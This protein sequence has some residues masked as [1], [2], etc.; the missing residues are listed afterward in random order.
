[1]LCTIQ[2]DGW[3]RA[4]GID[5]SVLNIWDLFDGIL[6]SSL[7]LT[8]RLR[9]TERDRVTF[10]FIQFHSMSHCGTLAQTR[11]GVMW[12]FR[13]FFCFS[14]L[15]ISKLPN[16]VGSHF[17]EPNS[18]KKFSPSCQKLVY[19]MTDCLEASVMGTLI[20]DISHWVKPIKFQ[21]KQYE[22]T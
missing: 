3:L 22:I 19:S 1:M 18:R 7:V 15:S 5:S 4:M 12:A 11:A 16:G 20:A 17:F 10:N 9:E 21:K 6:I 8:Q 2:F 13:L 14:N